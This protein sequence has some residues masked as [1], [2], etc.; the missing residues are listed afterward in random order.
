MVPDYRMY[1][2]DLVVQDYSLIVAG[3]II[4][5]F[6]LSFASSFIPTSKHPT[7]KSKYLSKGM[8]NAMILLRYVI[9]D[10]YA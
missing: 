4:D 9:T 1:S 2:N 8:Q 6:F 10:N 3:H 5:G 7:T